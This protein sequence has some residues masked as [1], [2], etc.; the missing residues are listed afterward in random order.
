MGRRHKIYK[1]MY[2]NIEAGS[3]FV[4]NNTYSNATPML[5]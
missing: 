4:G 1:M 3:L 2:V 5:F